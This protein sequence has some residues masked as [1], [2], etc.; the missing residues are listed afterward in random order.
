[1]RWTHFLFYGCD[2]RVHLHVVSVDLHANETS[3][4][5]CILISHHK[6]FYIH[7]SF[8]VRNI[9]SKQDE[10]KSKTTFVPR[11][12]TKCPND[13]NKS[14]SE[15]RQESLK[16]WS[17]Q[18]LF[19]VVSGYWLGGVRL[20]DNLWIWV[21]LIIMLIKLWCEVQTKIQFD[22]DSALERFHSSLI[23]LA[24]LADCLTMT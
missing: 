4:M 10:N 2:F 1:M 22:S 11:G 12:K 24:E 7:T 18:I 15:V 19:I 9:L 14:R 16:I 3:F 20:D 5:R 23:T 8:T 13:V 17:L 21:R 6:T